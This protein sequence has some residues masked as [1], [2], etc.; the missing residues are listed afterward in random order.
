M[1]TKIKLGILGLYFLL[2]FIYACINVD[3]DLGVMSLLGVFISL[4]FILE[5]VL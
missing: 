1:N 2:M 4:L 5:E 3:N